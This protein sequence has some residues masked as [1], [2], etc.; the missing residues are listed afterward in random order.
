MDSFNLRRFRA[1]NLL[2]LGGREE[3]L[4]IS[5]GK[6]HLLYTR[7]QPLFSSLFSLYSAA[8]CVLPEIGPWQCCNPNIQEKSLLSRDLGSGSE[9]G[10]VSDTFKKFFQLYAAGPL[11]LAAGQVKF[12]YMQCRFILK[13]NYQ[14]WQISLS[15]S[16]V[17][18]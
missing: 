1:H 4:S 3:P 9:R 7:I 12:C 14:R 5:L 8:R 16:V 17:S 6:K 15:F 18:R 13:N 2:E 11:S 10:L